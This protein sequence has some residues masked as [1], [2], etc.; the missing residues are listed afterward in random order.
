MNQAARYQTTPRSAEGRNG[1]AEEMS[2]LLE[3]G[4]SKDQLLALQPT[5]GD[6]SKL[7][8][9]DLPA[10][11]EIKPAEAQPPE[12]QELAFTASYD[13]GYCGHF[14]IPG[15]A[16]A[17]AAF[18]QVMTQPQPLQFIKQNLNFGNQDNG[19]WV[20]FT[21]GL[22]T[23]HQVKPGWEGEQT[24]PQRLQEQYEPVLEIQMAHM[25]LGT[26][27]DQGEAIVPLRPE[28]RIFLEAKRPQLEGAGIMPELR[29]DTAV[30]NRRQRDRIETIL[31]LYGQVRTRFR[32]S[33]V[34]LLEASKAAQ[35]PIV[36]LAYSRSS[37][38]L[39]RAL[40]EYIQISV[41]QRRESL[42]AV[43]AFLR[44]YVTVL[45]IGNAVRGWPDGPAYVHFSAMSDR[46][47]WE[48]S[49]PKLWGTDPLT[50]EQ[51]VHARKPQGAGKDAVFLHYDGLFRSFDTHNFGTVGAAALKLILDINGLKTF[52]A[53]WEQGNHLTIPNDWQIAA[54]VTLTAG[55]G[56]LWDREA[57]LRSYRLPS[58]EQA[59][60][61]LANL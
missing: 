59:R 40:S 47:K 28:T 3:L 35:Q 10:D 45:T 57:S 37:S 41:N 26:D 33:A 14:S 56:W 42:S 19:E 8:G 2:A 9:A 27:M 4:L 23:L 58:A 20:I 38:E 54:K 1:D 17:A 7:F 53:L 11:I 29:E 44:E 22:N 31:S 50:F 55:E 13:E 16:G 43:E 34:Q 52:R 36:W 48:A 61:I 32:E 51:G 18:E 6:L 25:H 39:C 12:L 15:Q 46:S 60:Q 21:P 5:L 49:P 24:A 30:F